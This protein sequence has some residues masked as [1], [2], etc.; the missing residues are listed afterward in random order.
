MAADIN[1]SQKG[2]ANAVSILVSG[3]GSM[4]TLETI[5]WWPRIEAIPRPMTVDKISMIN[6][7][8]CVSDHLNQWSMVCG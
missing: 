7:N 6:N 5:I 4:T 8:E 2:R 3:S 1:R